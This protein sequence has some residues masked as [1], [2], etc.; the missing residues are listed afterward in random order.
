MSKKIGL[1]ILATTIVFTWAC[2]SAS[3]KN[4]ERGLAS[5]NKPE[6]LRLNQ[7]DV[8]LDI[9]LNTEYRGV[10]VA[11]VG[12]VTRFVGIPGVLERDC[13]GSI[14]LWFYKDSKGV[15]RYYSNSRKGDA[16]NCKLPKIGDMAD[17]SQ[18]GMNACAGVDFN[19]K[20]VDL[21]NIDYLRELN[22]VEKHIN[23]P[24][25]SETKVV[26]EY[27]D[28]LKLKIFRSSGGMGSVHLQITM[29][30]YLKM[31]YYLTPMLDLHE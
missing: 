9:Y 27:K 30:K 21:N 22:L 10:Y 29:L 13:Y 16:A 11:D 31:N 3:S 6:V 12:A 28:T 5:A 2:T 25:C 4:S 8:P 17:L 20:N 7:L 14:S 26:D 1:I 18:N 15:L 23:A 19:Y 24:T